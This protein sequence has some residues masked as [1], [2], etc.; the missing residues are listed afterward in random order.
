[1]RSLYLG[2]ELVILFLVYISPP[3]S[4][5]NKK[6]KG[7]SYPMKLFCFYSEKSLLHKHDFAYIVK[8]CYNHYL[9]VFSVSSVFSIV[10]GHERIIA[11]KMF[12]AMKNTTI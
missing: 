4:L 3:N 6:K 10:S 11:V 12:R 1:M 5:K 9:F 7:Q 8:L 2:Y